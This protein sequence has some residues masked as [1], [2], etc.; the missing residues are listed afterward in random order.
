MKRERVLA[1]VLLVVFLSACGG[2]TG[3]RTAG[4]VWEDMNANGLRDPGDAGVAGV[5]VQFRRTKDSSL[6]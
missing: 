6:P 2:P 1:T 3:F 5:E 4:M